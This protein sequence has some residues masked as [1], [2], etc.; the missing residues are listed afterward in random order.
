MRFPRRRFLRLAGAAIALPAV[1]RIASAQAY[2]TR[3]VRLIIGYPPGGS[4]DITARLLGQWLSE[5]LRQ[6]V[7]IEN[8]PGAS[9]NIATQAVVRAPPD[10][11]KPLLVSPANAVKATPYEKPNINFI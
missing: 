6:A 5:R 2:P 8:R 3:P 7:V 10:G 1:S 9:T 4:A 11:Y